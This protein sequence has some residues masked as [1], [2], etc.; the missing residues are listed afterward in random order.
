MPASDGRDGASALLERDAEITA[1]EAALDAAASGT[2][3]LVVIEAAAG[4]GKTRLVDAAARAAG[5]R[6]MTTLTARGEE[7]E[8]EFAFG[9]MRQLFEPRVM[10][11]DAPAREDLLSGP[12]QL[13]G[14]LLLGTG[15]PAAPVAQAAID[16]ALYWLLANLAAQRPIAL[17]VDDA[18]WADQPSLHALMHLVVRLEGLP[19]AVVV[20]TRPSESRV[21][22]DLIDRLMSNPRALE[23][24]PQ[25]LTRSA[26][27]RLVGGRLAEPEDAF[28]SACHSATGGNPFLISELTSALAAAGVT[29]DAGNA[30]RVRAVGPQTVA[31]SVLLRLSGQPPEAA[32]VA[33]SLAILGGR[34]PL[35]QVARTAGLDEPTAGRAADAL[36]AV[37]ILSPERPLEFAHAIVRAAVY[38]SLPASVL[39]AGHLAAARM[40]HRDGAAAE[41]VAA[42]LLHT[43]PS[44]DA[45][46]VDRLREAASAAAAVGALDATVTYLERA[47]AEPPAEDQ[48]A[49]LLLA[50]SEGYRHRHAWERAIAALRDAIEQATSPALRVE[51][52]RRLC[53]LYLVAR[54]HEEVSE[55]LVPLIAELRASEPDLALELELSLSA[56]MWLDTDQAPALVA[57]VRDRPMPAGGGR[58]ERILLSRRAWAG[59]MTGEPA[60]SVTRLARTALGSG[61]LIAE[62]ARAHGF[63]MSVLALALADQFDEAHGHLRRAMDAART[64]GHLGR[65]GFLSCVTAHVYLLQGRLV[66]AEHHALQTLDALRPDGIAFP[67]ALDALVDVLLERAQSAAAWHVYDHLADQGALPDPLL[68]AGLRLAPARLEITLGD[69]RAGLRML[70]AL[71]RRQVQLGRPNPAWCAWR[72]TAALVR[73]KLGEST[74]ARTLAD[75]ELADARAFGANRAIGVALRAAALCRGAEG[76][77]LLREAVATLEHSGAELEHARAL[78]D[79]GAMLRRAGE[80]G[81]PAREPL[82]RGREIAERLGAQPLAERAHQELLAAGA[83]PRRTALQ[84]IDAL[85]PSE[86][87]VCNLAATGMSNR[88]IAQALFVTVKTVEGHLASSYRKLGISRKR[89][90]EETILTGR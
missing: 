64:L 22:S 5:A 35:G 1:I 18:Q 51:A 72:S 90:L 20:A 69:P 40:L 41:T 86:R 16:H 4:M 88:E 54:R 48:R 67:A 62:D 76:L 58:R 83:R 27:R 3:M 44:G 26:V 71:G 74:A 7:L 55:A 45:W 85:T 14:E 33:R 59:A 49:E 29:P 31:R 2:G 84:G 6:G 61:E 77:A 25:P 50:L 28:V 36:A 43:E 38:D 47:L 9:V 12:A 73:L 78:V 82:R 53:A 13:A 81:E 42:H 75:R 63:E 66:D 8:R 79:L 19:V 70:E 34:A 89:Q 60:E 37:D 68:F 21:E 11:L 32:A 17:L 56:P 80:R 10:R 57:M 23:L 46:A 15:E 39:S 87:R 52:A 30:A 24:R 65:W